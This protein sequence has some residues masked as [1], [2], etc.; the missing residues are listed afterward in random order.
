MT[1]LY[2]HI[3]QKQFEWIVDSIDEMNIKYLFHTGDIVNDPT[4]EYQWK[5]ADAYMKMLEDAKLP[6]GV[7]AGNHDVG[8]YDWDYTTYG[9]YFGK[10]V[11]RIS[12][13][14]EAPTRTTG[15][16]TIWSPS[17]ATTSS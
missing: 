9:Q 13:I 7:L 8:S 4:A 1:E 14:T 3:Q 6:H 16:I 11:I 2:P 10:T 15:D 5:R 12:P 17:K